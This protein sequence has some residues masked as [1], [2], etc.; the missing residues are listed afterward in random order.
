MA[1]HTAT[2]QNVMSHAKLVTV[3][4]GHFA[5]LKFRTPHDW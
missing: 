1:G 2:E 4:I 3:V 5:F